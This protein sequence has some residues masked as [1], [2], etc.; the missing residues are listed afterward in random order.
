MPHTRK[1]HTFVILFGCIICLALTLLTFGIMIPYWWHH[2]TSLIFL[3]LQCCISIAGAMSIFIYAIRTPNNEVSLSSY[4]RV[5]K[6][7]R[8]KHQRS[9]YVYSNHGYCYACTILFLYVHNNT[10]GLNTHTH[11]V[12]VLQGS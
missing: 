4:T 1:E 7:V 5:L 10:H 9:G 6:E 8:K 12:D 11:Y 2:R 3:K